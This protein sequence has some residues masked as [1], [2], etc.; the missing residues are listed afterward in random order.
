MSTV[1]SPLLTA[2]QVRRIRD[3]IPVLSDRPDGNVDLADL[4]NTFVAAALVDID[5]LEADSA[6][7]QADVD[8]LQ[9]LTIAIAIG[10]ASGTVAA[11]GLDGKPVFAMIV[12][13]ATD[14][15]LTHLFRANIAS[16]VLT[17]VGNANATAEVTVKCL[18][19]GR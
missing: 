1:T 18:V 17:V 6:A 7:A 5:A 15:T 13:A 16:D 11:V 2:E 8:A 4:L 10:A 9:V 12:Q 14:A 19:D 3:N